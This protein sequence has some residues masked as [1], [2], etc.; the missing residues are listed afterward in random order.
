MPAWPPLTLSP[1]LSPRA[2]ARVRRPNDHRGPS[3]Q[4]VQ[5]SSNDTP[6]CCL[7]RVAREPTGISLRRRCP[8]CPRPAIID[9]QRAHGRLVVCP[10]PSP[11]LA[12]PVPLR[13][14]TRGA[15]TLPLCEVD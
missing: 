8:L 6:G 9:L 13:P 4:K 3:R 7:L 11:P 5:Y 10:T 2:V 1:P 15:P 14:F 12:L